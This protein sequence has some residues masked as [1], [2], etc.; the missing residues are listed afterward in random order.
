MDGT[1]A[2]HRDSARPPAPDPDPEPIAVADA[3]RRF[4]SEPGI[5][6]D[7]YAMKAFAQRVPSAAR[8]RLR[9][10][11][12]A[13]AAEVDAGRLARAHDPDQ[14][15]RFS[16]ATGT[17][18]AAGL[19]AI[20]AIPAYLAAQAFGLDQWTTIGISAVLV[21]A[22]A[23]AM[24]VVAGDQAGRRRW[25]VAAVLA[26]GLVAIGA[27]RWW[28]LVVTTG[29][30]TAAVI[31]A[32]GLTIFTALLVWFGVIVLGVTKARHVSAAERRARSLRRQAQRAAVAE[33][34][35]GTRADAAMRELMG[36]AQVYSSRALDDADSRG[37]FLD[38]VRREVERG[39]DSPVEDRHVTGDRLI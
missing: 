13:A 12:E 3:Y 30:Q 2:I 38:R 29:D 20:D 1:P 31:E 27:L 21:A 14:R 10:R 23:A 5:E 36:R 33:A 28:Y 8:E 9:L 26:A 34:Q 37:R 18:I 4:L 6:N 24:W 17:A 25:A 16:F 35:A 32:F 19:A 22:L 15:R 39:I 7:F 11:D